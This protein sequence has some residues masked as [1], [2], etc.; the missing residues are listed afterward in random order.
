MSNL[1]DLVDFRRKSKGRRVSFNR[2]ELRSLLNVYSKRVMTGEWRDYAIDQ[3]GAVAVFSVFRNSFDSPAF[4][5]AKRNNGKTFEYVVFAG[6]RTLTRG[7]DLADVLKL[8][9]KPLRLISKNSV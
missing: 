9:D 6:R 3:Q 7:R 1:I 4:S 5:I 8:F 2:V